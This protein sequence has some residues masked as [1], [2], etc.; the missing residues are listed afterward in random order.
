MASSEHSLAQ[1]YAEIDRLVNTKKYEKIVPVCEKILA[2]SSEEYEA[3]QC[4]VSR[5]DLTSSSF[6]WSTLNLIYIKKQ[7]C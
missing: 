4:A 3:I 5:H 1:S 2:V 7:M 6:Y